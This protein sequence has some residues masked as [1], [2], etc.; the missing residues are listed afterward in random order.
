[1][2]PIVR[3]LFVHKDTP[4]G[5]LGPKQLAWLRE[6]IPSFGELEDRSVAARYGS[7]EPRRV[8]VEAKP[9]T[10]GETE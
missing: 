7:I 3:K 1:M 6:N 2:K 9:S 8:L 4:P 5:S 10:N